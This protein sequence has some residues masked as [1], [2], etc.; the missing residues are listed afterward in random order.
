MHNYY[1]Y[2]GRLLQGH[3]YYG[4]ISMILKCIDDRIASVLGWASSL[5]THQWARG[6]A[7]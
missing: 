5:H 1:M 2:T 6:L 7:A 4:I 3:N